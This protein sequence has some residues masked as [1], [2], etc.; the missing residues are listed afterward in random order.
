[1]VNDAKINSMEWDEWSDSY[2]KWAT[3]AR[4]IESVSITFEPINSKN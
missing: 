3:H 4:T 1:M 2:L